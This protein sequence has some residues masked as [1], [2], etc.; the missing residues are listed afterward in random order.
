MKKNNKKLKN[1][2]Q[3]QKTKSWGQKKLGGG[4]VKENTPPLASPGFP[5]FPRRDFSLNVS[6]FRGVK[7]GGKVI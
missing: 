1:K 3:K 2:K 7:T 6:Q 4:G 5:K